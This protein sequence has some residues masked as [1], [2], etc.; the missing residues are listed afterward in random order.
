MTVEVSA[1]PGHVVVDELEGFRQVRVGHEN[2]AGILSGFVAALLRASD[3]FDT[4]QSCMRHADKDLEVT[5]RPRLQLV[6][7]I[8]R[9][10]TLIAQQHLK[11]GE[12]T[13]TVMIKDPMSLKPRLIFI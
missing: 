11:H 10:P 1:N 12:P 4:S 2:Q 8:F 3:G 5:S 6:L 9:V 13:G 7:T